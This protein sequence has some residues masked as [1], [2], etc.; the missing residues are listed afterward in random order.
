MSRQR[1]RPPRL[2]GNRERPI[3]R[4]LASP[5]TNPLDPERRNGARLREL[6]LS[7]EGRTVTFDA[8][9]GVPS[10][11]DEL[12]R[13]L[14]ALAGPELAGVEFEERS[15]GGAAGDYELWAYPPAATDAG[16]AVLSA[17]ALNFG[18]W[19]DLDAVLGLLNVLL[20]DQGSELRFVCLVTTD[21][22]ATVLLGP[23]TA[24][25]SAAAEGLIEVGEASYAMNA[26]R[27]GEQRDAGPAQ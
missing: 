27:I 24:I 3:L 2:S 17:T 20:K 11:H 21:R 13:A 1:E 14:A 15:P 8:A 25:Q 4:L 12:L 16:D 19:Y 18:P 5:R 10:R 6:G 26:G 22:F 23:A 9:A 7:L